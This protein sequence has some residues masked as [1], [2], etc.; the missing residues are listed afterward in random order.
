MLSKV[1]DR[2]KLPVSVLLRGL[3]EDGRQ[4]PVLEF[5]KD[6][7]MSMG[8]QLTDYGEMLLLSIRTE[9]VWLHVPGDGSLHSQLVPL[10]ADWVSEVRRLVPIKQAYAASIA[11]VTGAT[12]AA[13]ATGYDGR[14]ARM[15]YL[16]I[17]LG[18]QS[19]E[20]VKCASDISL[21]CLEDMLQLLRE[22]ATTLYTNNAHWLFQA[23]KDRAHYDAAL[24]E[25][26]GVTFIRSD[27]LDQD[28]TLLIGATRAIYNPGAC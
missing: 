23:S 18:I 10:G 16:R 2:W 24:P 4:A 27:V 28:E 19:I 5:D 17:V 1:P 26:V 6:G 21:L 11:S 14:L 25:L 8:W 13:V 9:G 3:E 22:P 15:E 20:S 12:V 7:S